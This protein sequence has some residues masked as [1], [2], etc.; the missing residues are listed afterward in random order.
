MQTGLSLIFFYSMHACEAV[1]LGHPEKP[2]S[3]APLTFLHKEQHAEV[4]TFMKPSPGEQ[5]WKS[6]LLKDL[7]RSLDLHQRHHLLTKALPMQLQ[8]FGKMGFQMHVPI[9]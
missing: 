9:N 2:K 4:E 5:G 6:H 7:Y 8:S 1:L 3:I